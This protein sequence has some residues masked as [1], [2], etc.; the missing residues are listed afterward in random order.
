MRQNQR[1]VLILVDYFGLSY[2][3]TA[4]MLEIKQGTV[5]S[6]LARARTSLIKTDR[7]AGNTSKVVSGEA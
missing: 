4:T 3:E 6:R 5:M 1:A 7:Y 2:R